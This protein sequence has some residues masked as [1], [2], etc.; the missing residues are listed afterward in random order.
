MPDRFD[1][2][3]IGTGPAGEVAIA[4]PRRQG[5]HMAVV[6]RELIGGEC[7]YWGCIPSKTLL[8]PPETRAEARRAPGVDEPNLHLS[9]LAE[10]RD[11]MIRGLDDSRQVAGYERRGITV[12]K[13]QARILGP[14]RVQAGERVLEADRIIIATGSDTTAPPIDG[15]ADAGY[16]TNREATTVRELPDSITVL[17]GG[18]WGSSSASSSPAWASG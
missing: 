7:A 5:L 16:W 13:A 2:V 10:Y 11:W 6:E 1:A 9:P 12:V 8:R 4:R 18:A 15:L 17:G 14:G 3:V